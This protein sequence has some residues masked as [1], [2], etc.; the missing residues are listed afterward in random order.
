[1]KLSDFDFRVWDKDHKGCSNKDCKC[2][3]KFTYGEEAKVRLSEFKMDV[4]IELWTGLYD[5]NGK[6]IYDGDIIEYRDDDTDEI[7]GY[8]EISFNFIKGIELIDIHHPVT[9]HLDNLFENATL[10]DYLETKIVGNIHENKEL[11]NAK[12]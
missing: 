6:K 4:E 12:L 8:Y 5:K 10:G 3:S 11:I 7:L 2:Q 9:L 1:M